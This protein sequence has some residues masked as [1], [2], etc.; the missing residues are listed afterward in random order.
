MK[1]LRKIICV[2]IVSAMATVMQNC[3]D[4]GE[5]VPVRIYRLDQSLSDGSVM[6]DEVMMKGGRWLFTLLGYDGL[7]DSTLDAYNGRYAIQ[8]HK[9]AVD[10]AFHDMEDVERRLGAVF[11]RMGKELPSLPV[12]K[13]YAMIS[14]YRQSVM[15][16]DT[17]LFIGLNHYLGPDYAA[18]EYFPENVRENKVREKIPQDVVEGLV[19]QHYPYEAKSEYPTL[20]SRL[21]YEGA[22][23]EA[24]MR[25]ADVDERSALRIN[26][27]EYERLNEDEGSE[28]ERIVSGKMLFNSDERAWK[29]LES[30]SLIGHRIVKSYLRQNDAKLEELLLP[31][32][33][34][35]QQV[36]KMAGYH[37]K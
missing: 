11:R 16:V 32:F 29:S 36:L 19:R 5:S 22:I 9:S 7:S 12:P 6:D 25:V 27:E 37:P 2:T 14:P 33:Y 1:M 18:Y 4:R 20:L 34:N 24:V 13:V 15:T 31:E 17:L 8:Y 23:V 35:S 30:R 26:G 10:S 21:L 3:G 28:W